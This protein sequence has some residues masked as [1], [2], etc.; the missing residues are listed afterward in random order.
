MRRES[1]VAQSEVGIGAAYLFNDLGEPEID[2]RG[3]A[4]QGDLKG[5]YKT[6]YAYM[7]PFNRPSRF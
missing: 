2:Q 6:K 1:F 7:T 5:D 3:G 4:L